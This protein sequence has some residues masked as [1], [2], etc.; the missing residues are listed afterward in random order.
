MRLEVLSFG[1][2]LQFR[3]LPS[4]KISRRADFIDRLSIF[5]PEFRRYLAFG[6]LPETAL[7]ANIEPKEYFLSTADQL[8]NFDIPYL[9]TNI[10]RTLFTNLVK[11]L[12]AEIANKVSINRL[13]AG[14]ESSR[15]VLGEYVRL[16]EETGYFALCLNN[17]YRRTRAKLSAAK[18]I[19]SLNTNLSLAINGFDQ[20]YFND[21]RILGHY[22]E[23]YVYMR[24]RE[25]YGGKIEFYADGKKEIDFVTEDFLWEVKQRPT[26]DINKYE[27]IAKKL[28]KPLVIVTES[29]ME[30]T[31]KL[32]KIPVYLL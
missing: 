25:K 12:S 24:L 30:K 19:Y 8:I 17:F 16:L 5:R 27:E 11:T 14:L 4:V 10:D 1:E 3:Q 6:Q 2:Y 23:N 22:T 13:A 18:K 20:S 21:S 7:N 26:G 32:I 29:E 9:H 31:R 28:K 15:A